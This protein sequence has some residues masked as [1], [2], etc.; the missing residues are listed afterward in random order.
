[1]ALT[2][3][4]S[5]GINTGIQFAGVTT[6]ATLNASDN[7]LSVGGTVNFVSDVSIGGTVSIA[8]TLTYEDVT[9]VDAI[10]I[11][12]ARSEIKV[13][14]GIT[15]SKDGDIFATGISTFSEGIAGDLL[16]DDKIVHRGDTNTAIRFADADTITAETGGSERVRIDSSG[17][18]GVGTNNPT[19]KVHIQQSAVTSAPSR[20]SALYLENNANCEIQF[21]GNSSNDCQLR[22]GTS[23]NSF[24]G[25][26]EYELDNNNLIHYTNGS[27]RFRITSTGDVNIGGNFSQTDSRVHIQD[28]TR[29]LQEGTLTLSSAT[30]TNGAADNG[31]T[32]R[33]H[34]HDGSSERYQASIRG[35]K[36]NGTSGNY[37]GYLAFNTRPN[38]QGMVE[39][40]RIASGGEVS[41]GGFAPTA[42]D[43][44]LQLNGGLRIAGSA[45]ASDT[46]S[47]YIYR[48]SGVDNLNFA[49]NGVERVKITSGGLTRL[50]LTGNSS[51]VEP[52]RLEN[53]GSGGGANVGMVFYNGNGS[54][55]AGALARIKAND[56]GSYDSSLSFETGLKSA[57][58]D[59]TIE[60][61]RITQ[62]GYMALGNTSPQ[63]LLHVWPDSDNTTSAYMRVTAGDRGSSTGLQ[64]GHDVNGNFQ[65]QGVSNGSMYWST[66]NAVRM[67]LRN[68]H[69]D[70][71]VG[72]TGGWNDYGTVQ[73]PIMSYGTSGYPANCHAIKGVL[74]NT[75]YSEDGGGLFFLGAR[76][77]TTSDYTMAGWYTGN[78]TNAITSDRQFRFIADGNAYADGS[79]NGG[80]ADYA[81]F[82]EWLDGNT[83]DENRKGTSVVLEDGKIRAAT[84][85]DNT[86]NIIGV[87]SANP[88]VVG[89]SASER[90][91][92]KWITD[93][94][95]DPVYE[96]YT[97]TEWYD[98]TKK[99]KVN[100]ATDR[101]PSDVTVGDDS[102]VITKN[103]NGTNLKRKKLNPSW[104]STATYIPRKDRKEW[105]IVGL[106]GKLKVKSD[107]PV[108]T[109][110]IKI[111]EVSA[112]VHEYLIR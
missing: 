95:G 10:G 112:S 56:E 99:E 92:E 105:D 11:I 103:Q 69:P 62:T 7:V 78:D 97:I 34:G 18:F 61:M 26:I 17:N 5:I 67:S 106:M 100:Y 58:G 32:L 81:E 85:S 50:M 30:T 57:Q 101:I 68:D 88:V 35:A 89:D 65:I 36:E 84:G 9:N 102:I 42:G 39:R 52:L 91:K 72:A 48:T 21:V 87:I 19:T 33:F 27:E 31:S 74:A 109:K 3:I 71:V 80:G 15:L 4:G 20:S 107:Q 14:S 98:E 60:R 41:I 90:W 40:L 110:W 111:R 38:G 8:G 66:D 75:S 79:W 59:T 55:G 23:S 47:P 64:I 29:P 22:F 25:A 13:G 43:G 16:I 86:D 51:L 12:T 70:L 24:K 44:V 37:A 28:V 82:F 73:A 49:T 93:D 2:K 76:R 63:Q 54:T 1:M 53:I 83:S 45:S 6:I 96:E 94:F 46:T 108:G 104:D 77:T